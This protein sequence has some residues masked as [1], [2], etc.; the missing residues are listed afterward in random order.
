MH[1]PYRDPAGG[2]ENYVRTIKSRAKGNRSLAREE[3]LDSERV[4][5]RGIG[6]RGPGEC[7]G[8][9]PAA[10]TTFGARFVGQLGVPVEAGSPAKLVILV[11]IEQFAEFE[12]LVPAVQRLIPE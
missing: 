1:C 10:A 11:P 12:F 8:G 9:Q 5:F 4:V 3:A 2:R 6:T 7:L